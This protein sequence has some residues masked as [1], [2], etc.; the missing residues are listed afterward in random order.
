MQ[1]LPNDDACTVS[2]WKDCCRM[3]GITREEHAQTFPLGRITR[4][5]A[6]RGEEKNAV[7]LRAYVVKNS[8]RS[9][10]LPMR[11]RLPGAPGRGCPVRRV[12]DPMRSAGFNGSFEIPL[13]FQRGRVP[14]FGFCP[15]GAAR[16]RRHRAMTPARSRRYSTSSSS[17]ISPSSASKSGDAYALACSSSQPRNSSSGLLWLNSVGYTR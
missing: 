17:T 5:M 2:I 15:A 1:D 12:P 8:S 3:G 14:G 13:P 16:M 7:N 9:A 6:Q 4:I 10:A 11:G